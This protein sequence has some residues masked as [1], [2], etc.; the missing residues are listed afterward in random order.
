MKKKTKKSE[1]VDKVWS[2]YGAGYPIWEIAQNLDI[3]EYQVVTI[4]GIR[5]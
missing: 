1:L 3:T 2:M 4:L 5:Y